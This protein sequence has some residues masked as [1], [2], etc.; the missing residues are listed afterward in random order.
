[1]RLPGVPEGTI[2]RSASIGPLRLGRGCGSIAILL[3]CV[4]ASLPLSGRA[5][6]ND[7]S[8]AL[9]TGLF[10]EE[11]NRN[12]P[13]AIEAYE[14]VAKQFDQNRALAA[15]AIF[16][17]G[18]V[19]RKLGKTNEA[20]AF[21]QR[22]L[23][24]F[25]DQ[26]TL[27][28]LS[29]QN[30]AGMGKAQ[31]T[32]GATEPSQP[33][34][35]EPSA[36]AQELARTEKIIAQ[37]RGWD[38]SQ[39]RRL[40]PTLVP[41][42]EF[43]RLNEELGRYADSAPKE[44]LERR[45]KCRQELAERAYEILEQLHKRAAELKEFVAKQPATVA[46]KSANAAIKSSAPI[47]TVPDEEETEIRRIQAMIENSPD[48]I[49]APSGEDKLTPLCRAASKGQLR[50]A[51]FLMEHGADINLNSPLRVAALNGHKAM[52]ELLLARGAEVN[53]ADRNGR[54]A[55]LEA[56]QR[57]FL[58]VVETSLAA[59]ADP[60]VRDLS[61]QTPL[62]LAAKNG[63]RPVAAA[64]LAHGADPNAV[65]KTQPGYGV[66]PV[67]EGRAMFGAPLHFAAARGDLALAEL[68]LTNRADVKVR[69]IYDE[70][71][72]DVA[73]ARGETKV[74][75]ALLVAGADPNA[76]NSS[77][78]STALAL[79][80]SGGYPEVVQLLLEHGANPNATV[81]WGQAGVTPL[82]LAAS[83]N[84]VKSVAMLLK[85]EAKPGLSDA[86]GNTALLNAV[87]NR[88]GEMVEMLLRAGAEPD[89]KNA[90]GYPAL[91][92][93]IADRA[94]K[95]VA[96][97]LIAANADLNARDPDG[98]TALH[99]AVP[100]KQNELLELL[101]NAGADVNARD[102]QGRT[103]L[104]YAQG[105]NQPAVPSP[106]MPLPPPSRPG[107][108]STQTQM[109]A[110]SIAALLRSHGGRAD[111]PKLDRI[112]VTR[113][114]TG[115][116]DTVFMADTNGWNNFTLLELIAVQYDL[117]AE[118]PKDNFRS[119]S[120]NS[121][122]GTSREPQVLQF[123][124]LA[125]I[126]I[127]RA[128]PTSAP[129]KAEIVDVL[130]I[131]QSGD[132]SRDI[133]LKFGDVVEIPEA[134]HALNESWKGIP[135]S[136]V[137]TLQ[138]CLARQVEVIVNSRTNRLTLSITTGDGGGSYPNNDGVLS[139]EQY[140]LGPVLRRS[141]LPLSSSDLTRVKVTRRETANAKPRVW[142]V[143]CSIPDKAPDLW[144][145]D[146]DVIEVPEK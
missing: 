84:D 26:D 3:L 111:L 92:V 127:K 108:S 52:V 4:F 125:R 51:T 128:P 107:A 33:L 48:L 120:R 6:T 67:G 110:A 121:P 38:L 71:P 144:L 31:V 86:R 134:A 43:E 88:S 136:E 129:A 5:A 81:V 126:V 80:V 98:K 30:L 124:N 18:E 113:P 123:P 74:A 13:A 145:R 100:Q 104:D 14:K 23:R 143:D 106:G 109:D 45:E 115:Y 63:F 103:P 60:N 76:R 117:L 55:L 114:E 44:I 10:E 83:R 77:G 62:T 91:I 46:A 58:S 49:N 69:S 135:V 105:K 56:A 9:Q 99:W 29:Q 141:S 57:G 42:A 22:I 64:L 90:G 59:K 116:R 36:E 79:A 28:K 37:L 39:L 131:L 97:A 7:L 24:E 11:A 17:L 133:P 8:T 130:A 68:L 66:N 25:G 32:T 61:S 139:N 132:C 54:T 85:F 12:L 96:A 89:T 47:T 95:E 146:G 93:C 53:A 138:K 40:I 140:W 1:M 21:Y 82:M 2:Y 70:T 27:A 87:S 16:R 73:A 119:W 20:A 15:T 142:V 41:D 75:E 19:N 101:I 78:D 34:Q 50:V 112:E 72:L 118:S 122:A 94:S 35:A 137:S 102:N 65:S